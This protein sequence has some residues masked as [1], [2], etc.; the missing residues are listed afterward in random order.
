MRVLVAYEYSGVVRDAFIRRGAEAMSC[1]ILP[2]ESPGPHYQGSVL[3]L[4]D[5]PFDLVV[6]HPP[7]TYLANSGVQHLHRDPERWDLM[8]A[9]ARFF[10]MMFHFNAPRIAV[11][12]PVQ[13]RYAVAETGRGRATQYVQPWQFGHTESKRTGFWLV[14]LP[15]L[16]PTNVVYDEMMKL[17]ISERQPM[18]WG[19]GKGARRAHA[20]SRT[21]SGIA[22]AM[23]AQWGCLPATRSEA[24]L[25]P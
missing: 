10:D 13:H 23:A 7:C 17:P 9:G 5:E 22:E 11:E 3:D 19:K 25:A 6:A 16:R 15:P 18:W 20:R 24:T 21:F 4:L 2:T 1:D 12:N 8:R 14:N